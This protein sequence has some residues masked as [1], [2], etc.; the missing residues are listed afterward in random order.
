MALH[1]KAWI[2]Y[3][4]QRTTGIYNEY[5]LA[6]VMLVY[7]GNEILINENVWLVPVEQFLKKMIPG[8]LSLDDIISLSKSISIAHFC[9]YLSERQQGTIS[10]GYSINKR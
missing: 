4:Y 5:P 3:I 8:K 10:Q 2:S 6:K 7:R 9:H 1:L